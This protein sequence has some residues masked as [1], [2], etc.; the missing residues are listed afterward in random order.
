[1]NKVEKYLD[2][3]KLQTAG[4][5]EPQEIRGAIANRISGILAQEVAYNNI[6]RVEEKKIKEAIQKIL[7]SYR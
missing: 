1:M 3:K 4:G 6:T 7:K 2:E 5:A